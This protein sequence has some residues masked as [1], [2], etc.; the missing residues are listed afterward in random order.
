MAPR[1]NTKMAKKPYK[2]RAATGARVGVA[3]K[4]YVKRA[5]AKEIEN[6]EVYVYANN[7]GISAAP[8]LT[9]LSIKLSPTISQGLGKSQ[10]TG[11]EVLIKNGLIK[12][13]VNLLPHSAGTN[14]LVAP[15]YVKIWLVSSKETNSGL[16]AETEIATTFFDVN[17]A[18]V[19]FQG[20]MLDMLLRPNKERWQVHA[21]KVVKLGLA[22][23]PSSAT[24]LSDNGSF[25]APYQFSF[26]K[27]LRK[28]K[29]EDSGTTPTN[30]NL[31]L[32]FSCAYADGSSGGSTSEFA[33]THYVISWN[34]T[35]A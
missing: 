17:N 33:E 27:H 18:N 20:N 29:F 32:V 19:G 7:Q 21:T 35:D 3:V 31:W 24:G 22:N 6:K 25:S 4:Q 26:G 30:K 16:I 12:G 14:P 28:L 13:Y 5:L 1:K 9:P 10:R 11:D 23:M 15:A 34:Y 2:K 8:F